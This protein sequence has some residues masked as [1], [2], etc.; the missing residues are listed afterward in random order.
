MDPARVFVLGHSGGGKAAPRV[1][2]AEASVA[3]LVIMAADALPLSRS[4]V[5]VARYLAALDASQGMAAAA[6]SIARQ[7]ARV[8]SAALSPAAPAGE[9]LFG[10]PASYWLDL[11]EYDRV[12]VAAALDRPVL[13]LQGRRDYRVT[14]DDDLTRWQAGL[15]GRPD[16]TIRVYDADDHMFFWRW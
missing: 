10:W 13:V 15:A 8:E 1:A 5:R 6:R 3:G 11:R 16:V 12:A 9:L 7:A 14:V 4:A 2:A